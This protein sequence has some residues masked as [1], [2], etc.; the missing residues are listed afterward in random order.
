MELCG[1]SLKIE[2]E[3]Y[4]T[5]LTTASRELSKEGRPFEPATW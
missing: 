1:I 2:R 4:I 3:Q 5:E